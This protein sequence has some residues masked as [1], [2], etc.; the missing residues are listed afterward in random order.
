[1]SGTH[2]L[3]YAQPATQTP[4]RG[5]A[6]C[7]GEG[8]HNVWQQGT[9]PIGN[10]RLGATVWGEIATERLTLNE[11]TLWTGGP[12]SSPTYCGGNDALR[13][14][15]GA[16]LRELN[17][18]LGVDG[19]SIDPRNLT[20]GHEPLEQGSYQ[21]WGD[22]I[23]D[24]GFESDAKVTDYHRSLDLATAVAS[25]R[26]SCGGV[27]Y[28][29][30]FA[31]SHPDQVLIAHLTASAPGALNVYIGAPMHPDLHTTGLRTVVDGSELTT[32][33]QLANNGL[34]FA[35]SLQVLS[36]AAERT[37]S[38][39]GAGIVISGA[40]SATILV[41]AATDYEQHYPHYRSGESEAEL[42]AR[43]MRRVSKA[44]AKG[45]RALLQDHIADHQALYRRVAVDLEAEE[46][47]QACVPDCGETAPESHQSGDLDAELRPSDL[48]S[49]AA[50]SSDCLPSDLLLASYPEASPAE[51]RSIE[52]LAF[53]YGRYLLMAASREDSQLPANLQGM[54]SSTAHDHAHGQTPWGADFHLNVNLQMAY[55]PAYATG[56]APCTVPL[57]SFVRGLVEPGRLTAQIYAGAITPA[58][59]P[60]GEGE[61][62]MAHTENTP[63]GWTTPGEEFSWG[64]SPAGVPWILH[65]VYEA[66][67]YSCDETLLREEIYPLLKEQAHFYNEYMLQPAPFNGEGG[68]ARLVTGVAY[69]PEHGP[70]GTAGNTYENTLI[71]QL[72]H[73]TIE[74]ATLLGVDS[75][76]VGDIPEQCPQDCPQDC[77]RDQQQECPHHCPPPTA[78]NWARD[79]NGAFLHPAA[80]R[81]WR[82]ALALLEPIEI[83]SEGQIKEWYHEQ[84]L[85]KQA[86]GNWLPGYQRDHH[87]RHISHLLGLY[88]GDL[89]TVD[90]SHVLQA[91]TVSLRAR[92]D[93]ATGWGL[94]HRLLCWARMGE[95]DHAHA[96]V[97]RMLTLATY[98]NFFG[99][100][101]PF[102]IDGN[103]GYTAGVTEM[104]LQSNATFVDTSQR[105]WT[106]YLHILPALP[107]AWAGGCARGLEA[108][109]AFR[110]DIHWREGE[111]DT[112][113]LTS[114]Q[115]RDVALRI[116][117]GGA[118][119]YAVAEIHS[120]E[121]RMTELECLVSRWVSDGEHWLLTFPT[122][123]GYTYTIRRQNGRCSEVRHLV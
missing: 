32:T 37:A 44:A 36:D 113:V 5:E 40:T 6:G 107:Q 90:Q 109:G 24:Y 106:N 122:R 118:E 92:G 66:Y 23:L 20:G 121:G 112:L 111:L 75:E 34:R 119:H 69:S 68:Q 63:F 1:M 114:E 61:G 41:A 4:V 82:S 2:I 21:C 22:L 11:E 9:L 88:P 38:E 76:L 13:G 86:D 57:W 72:L 47:G 80:D 8:P 71:W 115:G 45:Y 28:T 53:H 105:S 54:W 16:T 59:T 60:I 98:P 117:A 100:H 85:G 15:Y 123:C 43:V 93:E 25:V 95:G 108:R 73:D 62:Y 89:I 52:T 64:W 39:D 83:G 3:W 29:R 42:R 110:L 96:L 49:S 55:W 120:S 7:V 101:P 12:G 104:L 48:L 35:L 94:A 27:T 10:G 97:R 50:R 79:E 87:H 81:S 74:A 77:S 78:E 19:A 99:A 58:G 31:V 17:H 14:R 30:D 33:G 102:Q 91:A 18:Q 70:V 46:S 103:C 67:E 51:Q 116:G 56:L 26:L 65:N 84:A